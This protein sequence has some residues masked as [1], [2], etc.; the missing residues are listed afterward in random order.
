[1]FHRRVPFTGCHEYSL[2]TLN[3]VCWP[4][5]HFV[6]KNLFIC[7]LYLRRHSHPS[8]WDRKRESLWL[9]QGERPTHPQG[10]FGL[11]LFPARQPPSPLSVHSAPSTATIR[12]CLRA[13]LAGLVYP[14]WAPACPMA[15]WCRRG[16][17]RYRK[18]I[19]LIDWLTI[20]RIF[21]FDANWNVVPLSL[22]SP[23]IGIL[24]L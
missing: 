2:W 4:I 3:F 9:F 22:V 7:R 15:R 18:L 20:F 10:H 14:P 23:G 17:W 11:V 19:W 1:M 13:H 5:K 24:S 6:E 21:S 12:K 16:Y 8:H